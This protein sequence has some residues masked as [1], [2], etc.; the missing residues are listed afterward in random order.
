MDKSTV[1]VVSIVSN[2]NYRRGLPIVPMSI[3][4]SITAIPLT[5]LVVVES[6]VEM[7]VADTI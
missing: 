6:T 1:A 5:H 7:Q 4:M 3:T 2:S